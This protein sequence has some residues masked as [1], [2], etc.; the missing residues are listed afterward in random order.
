MGQFPSSYGNV[1]ILFAVDYV[2]KWVEAKATMTDDSK[3]VVDF[4]KT[5]IFNRF[6]IP[7][8]IISNRGTYFYNQAVETLMKRY[9]VTHKV[10][11][12]YHP[13]TSG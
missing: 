7:K 10:S 2:S 5:Y 6:G 11:T 4:V 13:Q 9:H 1:Y 12:A 8:V 3:F